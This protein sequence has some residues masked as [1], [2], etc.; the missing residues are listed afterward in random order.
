MFG[1]RSGR[2]LKGR[3]V[4]LPATSLATK[5]LEDNMAVVN[6]ILS[7]LEGDQRPYLEISI[8]DI[9]LCGL[10]DS[11]A[12]LSVI[13]KSGWDL[14][15]HLNL[16]L[17]Q[18]DKPNCKVANGKLCES[19]GSITVPVQLMGK[20][21]VIRFAVVPD[22]SS[23]IILG[24][25]F[26]LA[27]EIVP[28]LR[29]DEWKFAAIAPLYVETGIKSTS[30]LTTAQQQR[31]EEFLN[32]NWKRMRKSLGCTNLVQHKI[33]SDSAPIKQR[34]YPV[35]P[36]MQK[37]I[38]LE[39]DN[40]IKE[41]IVEP[42][43][44]SWSSPILMVP[45]K[46]GTFRFCVDYR[47]LNKVT[48][49]DAYPIPYVSAILDRLKGA[50]YLSSLDIKSAYWQIPVEEASRDFTAFT[51]P[52]RG[53]FQ[54][55]RMP[56]GLTN[57]PA[58]W[59]RLIDRVLGADLEPYVFVYL[60]DI[61][62]ITEDFEDHLRI[63]TKIFERL[64]A[65]NLT[66]SP[67]KCQFCR[68]ELRYLGYI[69]DK[70]GLRV[71]PE[72]V[73][74]ILNIPT[75]TNVSEMRRFL[76]M[77]SWYRR[78][79]K[80]FSTIIS[81][82]TELLRKNRK[83][84]WTEGCER[85]FQCIKECLVTAPI[86]TCPDFSKPFVVQTDASAYGLG[87]VLTQVY[88]DGEHVVCFLSRSLNKAERN[89]STTE[90]ECLAV[91]W[92]LEKLRPYLEGTQFTVVTDHH[93]LVWLNNLKDPSGRLCRWA[94]KL[95]QHSF[96]IVH[97]K[98]REHLVPDCLSRSVEVT[99]AIQEQQEPD[100]E[101]T[102]DTWYLS[103]TEKIR[104]A[105]RKYPQWRYTNG[106]LFKYVTTKIPELAEEQ[107]AW[108]LVIPKDRRAKIIKLHHDVPTSGHSGVTKTY[109]SLRRKY[110]WPKMKSDVAAYI[111]KCIT[112]T[113]HK[114]V[115][116]CAPGFMGTRPRVFRPFQLISTDIIGPLPRSSKGYRYILVIADYYSKFV[117]T[118]PLRTATAQAVTR[119]MENDVFL[120]FGV[121]QYLLCD[122][123]VQFKS[124][125][126]RNLCGKYKVSILFNALYHP[127]NNPSER[128]NRVI[129][130]MLSSY[131]QDNHQTWDKVLPSV[132][133]A[134][135]TL[136]H[137]ATGYTPYFVNFGREHIISGEDYPAESVIPDQPVHYDR[138]N[139]AERRGKGFEKL[140]SDV[141]KRLD[142]AYQ[143]SR[144]Q[145]NLRRRPVT[146]D[147]GQR[148][149]RR[150]FALSNAAD[151]FASKLAPKYI[152]P[153]VIHRKTSSNT[154]ELCD[155]TGRVRGVWHV[156]DLKRGPDEV[157]ID[158][159]T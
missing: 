38:D 106:Q 150:N 53:L 141:R 98:G 74:A 115:Q 119:H 85:A 42:S 113:E 33:V 25:D 51:I 37:H 114:A 43:Q 72:K 156:K 9:K 120:L 78:F 24:M 18:T 126:F 58:T 134:I 16:P 130:T 89:Y 100:R 19:L 80:D 110:Y 138:E 49:K 112:C 65:A 61:I 3:V 104:L 86:L 64:A 36:A 127:Q 77:A 13:G 159:D 135:R 34:Y 88:D 147:I 139:I 44:S 5:L 107:D 15:R 154:Y 143:Q 123:G 128:V 111:R 41:G 91:V 102:T 152:G 137:E 75:P 144:V 66:L 83:W 125:D 46:D 71:D 99:D 105:P 55:R 54:F 12:S 124:T 30:D 73:T 68:S 31:L 109:A 6:Y 62:V 92:S 1:K 148:V 48:K 131:V 27:M 8:F 133:C 39:L 76:G 146:Y 70:Q 81:P 140:Y 108:K 28:D 45:K 121:P 21:K 57:A 101:P 50:K 157:D 142:R 93:S 4:S 14:L 10:L 117:L 29:R 56:F 32:A 151:Q 67:D 97:R 158:H 2:A 94:V 136:V 79:V 90:R 116:K 69:V 23:S 149:W 129:K 11:G 84:V 103:M 60:D 122:N 132:S 47:R 118:F 35:S 40:M 153:F 82:L 87:A 17:D 95:Q 155:H 26:W 59:Q 96:D 20:I 52:G 22:I 63:L 145:Y 7:H